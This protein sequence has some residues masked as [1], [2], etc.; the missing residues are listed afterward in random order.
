[1][2]KDELILVVD[3]VTKLLIKSTIEFVICGNATNNTA[4]IKTPTVIAPTVQYM[5][6]DEVSIK[7]YTSFSKFL[8]SL[9]E[10]E[11]KTMNCIENYFT[12]VV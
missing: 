6:L 7:N 5:L 9:F 10:F 4:Q 3:F 2:P 1:M 12:N 8:I 11:R